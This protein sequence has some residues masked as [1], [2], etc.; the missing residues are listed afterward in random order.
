MNRRRFLAAVGVALPAS[1][2]LDRMRPPGADQTEPDDRHTERDDQDGTATP[3]D[4]TESEI[5]IVIRNAT[6]TDQPATVT[7]T[8]DGA[9]VLEREVTAVPNG[10]SAL[11]T[12]ID[13]QGQYELTVAVENGPR[14][15]FPFS[16]DEYD[17]RAGSNLI[18][19]IDEERV[20][21]VIEE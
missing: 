20:E 21:I 16:V 9:T 18:V 8:N 7:L 5:A 14:E 6:S 15:T 3:R 17:L 2:C 4:E 13:Q 12:G 1:G 19:T 11:E 10:E